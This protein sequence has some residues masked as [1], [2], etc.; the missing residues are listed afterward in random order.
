MGEVWLAYDRVL[1]RSVALKLLYPHGKPDEQA[2]RR[3]RFLREAQLAASVIHRNVVHTLDFG[4]TARGEA[5]MVMEVLDGETLGDR[6]ER[7]PLT[8]A[9]LVHVVR[10][11]TRGLIAVHEA[12]IVHRDLKPDNV[13]LIEDADGIFP[14]LL[15]FGISRDLRGGS[16]AVT[17]REGRLV[18]TPRYMSPEQARGMS[19]VD[20]R[21]DLYAA[22]VLL[23]EALA[24]EPPFDSEN[25]GDL[26][27]QIIT[28]PAP[29]LSARRPDLDPELCHIVE[30]ALAKDPAERFADAREMH[31]A[32]TAY[33]RRL[34]RA[35]LMS[36]IPRTA[37]S[38]PPADD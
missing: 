35:P 10:L 6:L 5:F 32:L 4:T 20:R 3:E 31:D 27:I 33:A 8:V 11:V 25:L 14:K 26:M 38:R 22:G 28:E 2:R 34:A 13:F 15:D 36:S 12:G 9:Q 18:G 19:H 23:Y 7:E 29:P 24:G 37:P 21:T 16:S 17:T 30:R 1:A